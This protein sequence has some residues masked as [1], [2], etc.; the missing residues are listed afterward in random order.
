[1]ERFLIWLSWKMPR[2]LAYWVFIR[3]AVTGNER[4]PADQT[5]GE[6]ARRWQP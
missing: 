3:V 4:Y 1:M 2:R 5:V 6:V